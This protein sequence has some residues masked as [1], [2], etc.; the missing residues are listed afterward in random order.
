MKISDILIKK[1][2]WFKTE[3][4]WGE[5]CKFC[6]N[7]VG[8]GTGTDGITEC[9]ERFNYDKFESFLKFKNYSLIYNIH[10]KKPKIYIKRF[11]NIT[12][13]ENQLIIEFLESLNLSKKQIKQIKQTIKK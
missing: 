11:T 9:N 5:H 13:T 2:K 7:F 12:K 8:I 1:H 3:D 10:L 4:N 6:D